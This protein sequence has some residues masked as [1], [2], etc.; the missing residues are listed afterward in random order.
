MKLLNIS[1]IVY[2]ND[3]VYIRPLTVVFQRF[4]PGVKS[5]VNILYACKMY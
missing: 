1:Q 5:M 3:L 4:Y 2:T